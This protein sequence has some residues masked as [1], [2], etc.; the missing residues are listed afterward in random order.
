MWRNLGEC[1]I[2]RDKT[3][4]TV[5]NARAW[6]ELAEQVEKRGNKLEA[7][8]N[9]RAARSNFLRATNYYRAAL[10]V[11][12]PISNR[13]EH[14]QSWKKS[15]ELFERVGQTFETP[16]QRIDVSFEEGILPCY[17]LKPNDNEK[18]RPTLMAITG[19][20]GSTIEMYFWIGAEGF[21]VVTTWCSVI[22]QGT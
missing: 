7:E 13:K 12:S 17:L 11:F 15:T 21:G 1:L 8:S 14:H 6:F 4:D 5:S 18:N 9:H 19:G 2:V 20:E 22:F 3:K 16:M 10:N